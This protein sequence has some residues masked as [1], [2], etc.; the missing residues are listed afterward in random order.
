MAKTP[1]W[2]LIVPLCVAVGL[3][4]SHKILEASVS[5]MYSTFPSVAS[6]A[7]C[8]SAAVSVSLFLQEKAPTTKKDINVIL[9]KLDFINIDFNLVCKATIC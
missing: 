4:A 6:A 7:S 3:D 8:N 9:I 2:I 5:T 1:D